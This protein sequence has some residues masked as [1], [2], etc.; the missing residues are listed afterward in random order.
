[1]SNGPCSTVVAD[2]VHLGLTWPLFLQR[3]AEMERHT[4]ADARKARISKRKAKKQQEKRQHEAIGET[5]KLKQ[6]R[7]ASRMHTQC[8]AAANEDTI[9]EPMCERHVVEPGD[10][11]SDTTSDDCDDR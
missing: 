4:K 1:M 6:R 9:T 5:N 2:I 10:P 11:V 7:T 8:R 3:F